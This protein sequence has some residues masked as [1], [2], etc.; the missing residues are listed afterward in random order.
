LS[1]PS[2]AIIDSAAPTRAR[3]VTDPG[4]LV[5]TAHYMSPEQAR[6]VDVDAR[7]DI[8]S[9]GVV[10]YE[11]IAG[12]PPF[13]GQTPTEVIAAIIN[14]EPPL[15]A[16]YS[17]DVPE[18]LEWIVTKTLRKN[19]DE[20]YQTAKELLADLRQLKQRLEFS[21]EQERSASSTVSNEATRAAKISEEVSQAQAPRTIELTPAQT[22][23][24]AEYI[25]NQIKRHKTG[26]IVGLTLAIVGCLG[27][28]YGMYRLAFRSKPT[29]LHFQNM[30]I[31]KL[32]TTGNVSNATI[33]PDGRYVVYTVSDD[34]LKSL[35]TKYLPTGSTV[36]VVA[37]ADASLLGMT[38][39]S[40]DG[41]FV[42]YCLQDANH[43]TG[44]LFR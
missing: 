1:E 42:Y 43:T 10:L 44:A 32:T 41:N 20:R 14:S 40:P 26:A 23:S 28:A 25:V 21:A 5:G 19:R 31:T 38:T 3:V 33:S 16:R 9:F 37:P 30:K 13:E 34:K 4:M 22:T 29:F 8:F 24:S 35:W 7:T 17:R 18:A 39:F 11:M 27:L 2:A 12:R 15:L 6:G 36:E